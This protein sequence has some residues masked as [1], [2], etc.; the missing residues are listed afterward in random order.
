MEHSA[1][2]DKIIANIEALMSRKLRPHKLQNF[3]DLAYW[4]MEQTSS[5][6]LLNYDSQRIY[7]TKIRKFAT[8]IERNATNFRKMSQSSEK[9]AEKIRKMLFVAILP[10]IVANCPIFVMKILSPMTTIH[11]AVWVELAHQG[12]TTKR[13][14]IRME[15][16]LESTYRWHF[17]LACRGTIFR[18]DQRSNPYHYTSHP[19][20]PTQ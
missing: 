2:Y 7:I 8:K 14:Q 5:R 20:T 1:V 6:C 13:H 11:A 19:P 3:L 16:P 4:K 18:C 15:N 17:D 9:V 12:F 10:K